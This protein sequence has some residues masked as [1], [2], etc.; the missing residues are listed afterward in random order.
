MRNEVSRGEKV[1]ERDVGGHKANK[2]QARAVVI[3]ELGP[4]WPLVLASA[5]MR[6][7]KSICIRLELAAK[8]APNKHKPSSR[9]SLPLL[10]LTRAET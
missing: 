3:T 2:Q 6:R 9:P 4:V 7:A 8:H 1:R 10:G 5:D